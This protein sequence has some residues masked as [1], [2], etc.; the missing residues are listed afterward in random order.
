[1]AGESDLLSSSVSDGDRP[2][3]IEEGRSVS[4]PTITDFGSVHFAQ[5]NVNRHQS[6]ADSTFAGL[7]I[8]SASSSV[9][10]PRSSIDPLGLHLVH[11]PEHADGD[12]VFV[13][14]LGG[15][16]F[17]TWSWD[18]DVDNF[19]PKWLSRDVQLC[20]FRI[21]TFGY[22]ANFKGPH[23]GLSIMDFAKDLLLRMLSYSGKL[24]EDDIGIGHVSI[25]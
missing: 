14:G 4:E 6:V 19:W 23:T 17:R 7:Q 12:I 20:R 22:N 18:R 16:S 8:R 5:G 9:I 21:F 13:H 2:S 10:I 25:L 24:G 3:V 1:M 11:D 15:S